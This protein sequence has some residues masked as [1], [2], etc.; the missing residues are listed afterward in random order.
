MI[1]TWENIMKKD[2][3]NVDEELE[4]LENQIE[5]F[6][7]QARAFSHIAQTAIKGYTYANMPEVKREVYDRAVAGIEEMLEEAKK[8]TKVYNEAIKNMANL[9]GTENTAKDVK[10]FISENM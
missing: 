7:R 1:M 4:D 3:V 6:E 2:Y 5:V 10:D 8:A 9:L